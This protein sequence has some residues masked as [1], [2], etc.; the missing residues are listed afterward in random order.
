M[1]S[2]P[3]SVHEGIVKW[4]GPAW[5]GRGILNIT[6]ASSLCTGHCFRTSGEEVRRRQVTF[7]KTLNAAMG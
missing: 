1:S 3:R 5:I 2:V 7:V 4:A 6:A